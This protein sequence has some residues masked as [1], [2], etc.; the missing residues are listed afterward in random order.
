MHFSDITHWLRGNGL[1]IVLFATGAALLARFIHWLSRRY[2]SR[3]ERRRAATAEVMAD[4][5]LRHLHTLA[6]AAEWTT[7]GVVYFVTALLIVS[8]FEL[9]LTSLVAPATAIG[10]AIGFGAQRIVQDLL[11]G[12]FLFSE[13]QYVYGDVVQISGVGDTTGISGTVEELTLRTTQL[14]TVRGELVI[15]PNGSVQQVVNRS[16]DWSRVIIDV[17]IPIDADL[18][19]ATAVLRQ[20]AAAMAADPAWHT[21]L[22][23]QPVVAG[24]ESIQAGSVLLRITARTV[25]T[26]QTD[27]AR[28]LR[29]RI[30]IGLR[31]VGITSTATA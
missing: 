20:E 12:F 14:R 11:A 4:D 10:A 6:Q 9:P 30:A 13:R 28:E 19:R 29:R 5:E 26:K 8:R 3:L 15:I 27:V 24:V 23:D 17:P 25:P 1:E 21:A 7:L 22:L 2:V 18:D 31:E 16:R